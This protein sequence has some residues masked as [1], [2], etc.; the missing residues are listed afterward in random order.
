VNV[1]VIADHGSG[2]AILI[3]SVPIGWSEARSRLAAAVNSHAAAHDGLMLD[4]RLIAAAN[5]HAADMARHGYLAHRS[6]DGR[7]TEERV[8]DAG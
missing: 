5:R 3:A 1:Q 4:R 6:L 7:G 2:P 8:S